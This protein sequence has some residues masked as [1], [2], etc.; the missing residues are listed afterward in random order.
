MKRVIIAAILG[1]LVPIMWLFT[2]FLFFNAG[3]SVWTRL[4]WRIVHITCPPWDLQAHGDVGIFLVP[5][6]NGFLYALVGLIF[7][8]VHEIKR[9]PP[10]P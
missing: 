6:A 9:T 1:F 7:A 10:K 4:Y 8:V 3:E 5:I 2:S